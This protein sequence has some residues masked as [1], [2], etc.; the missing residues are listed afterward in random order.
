MSGGGTA[1]RCLHSTMVPA[2]EAALF[3]LDAASMELVAVTSPFPCLS[4][5]RLRHQKVLT[6]SANAIY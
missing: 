3:V 2:D 5:L 1:I 6:P 4:R